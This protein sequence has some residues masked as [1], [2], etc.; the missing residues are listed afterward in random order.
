[1]VR[2]GLVP[3]LVTI[4]TSVSDVGKGIVWA[5]V[6]NNSLMS[7]DHVGASCVSESFPNVTVTH[8]NV[9]TTRLDNEKLVKTLIL[10]EG[11]RSVSIV[12]QEDDN[13]E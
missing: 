6:R 11:W 8:D 9:Y 5:E 1:M 4:F 12:Y 7:D 2:F 3:V 10:L 13:S